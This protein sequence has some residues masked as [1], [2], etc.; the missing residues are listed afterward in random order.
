MRHPLLIVAA[1]ACALLPARAAAQVVVSPPGMTGSWL[2]L[3][4]AAGTAGLGPQVDF[5]RYR[6]ARLLRV[7]GAVHAGGFMATTSTDDAT[8]FELSVLAGRGASCCGSNW[9]A[10]AI[11][12]GVVSVD[13]GGSAGTESKTTL[14][15]TA[16]AFILSGRFP[17][18]QFAGFANLNMERP[19]AGMSLSLALGRMPFHSVPGPRRRFP[20]V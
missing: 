4:L 16:E 19:F 8:V 12:G 6:R 5:S 1:L 9:G 18:L 7:R 17:N 11:G 2:G 14:G 15:A 10:W 13:R 3:G 20:G